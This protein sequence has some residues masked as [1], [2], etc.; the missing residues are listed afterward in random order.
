MQAAFFDE[1]ITELAESKCC[2]VIT[3][4]WPGYYAKPY[5]GDARTVAVAALEAKIN[6]PTDGQREK[7]RIRKMCRRHD[8]GQH[9]QSREAC[10]VTHQ[11][12]LNE[13]LNRAAS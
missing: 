13:L 3:K 12:Q 10:R 4:M 9:I 11:G 7:V 5:I 2:L 6:R 1:F 8:P